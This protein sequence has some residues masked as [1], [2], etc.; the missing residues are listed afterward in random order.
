MITEDALRRAAREADRALA[1]SLPDPADCAHT[2]S[3]QFQRRMA[4]LIRRHRYK[5]LYRGLRRAACVLL[6]I[7]LGGTIFLSVNEEAQAAFYGWLREHVTGGQMYTY[8][9]EP[10]EESGVVRYQITVPEEYR[11]EDAIEGNG[12]FEYCYV[13]EEEKVLRFSY[14]YELEGGIRASFID[15]SKMAHQQV[16]VRG[17]PADLYLSIQEGGNNSLIWTERS[18]GV[19]MDL[20]GP[21]EKETLLALAET[22]TPEENEKNFG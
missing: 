4:R 7:L 18:T 17:N 6:A 10:V 16:T 2:F 14:V 9:G 5:G 1:D 12:Y 13:N 22:V 15:E 8:Q 20:T 21:L 11:L 19:L 3:P